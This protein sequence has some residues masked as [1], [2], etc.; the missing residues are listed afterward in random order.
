MRLPPEGKSVIYFFQSAGLVKIGWTRN[1][2]SRIEGLA[3]F[4]PCSFTLL[5]FGLGP[6]T[7]EGYLHKR[8]AAQH[9]HGE[10]FRPSDELRAIIASAIANDDNW[11]ALP[12][13]SVAEQRIRYATARRA[14]ADRELTAEAK[15]KGG[16]S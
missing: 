14:K 8:F 1:L 4:S 3:A 10:W 12:N 2:R 13:N 11:N 6:K 9:S 5:G 15:G 16:K 7:R